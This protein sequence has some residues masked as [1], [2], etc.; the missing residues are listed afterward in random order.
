MRFFVGSILQCHEFMSAFYMI[1]FTEKKL[2][3]SFLP[4][5][6]FCLTL[7]LFIAGVVGKATLN[8]WALLFFVLE[9]VNIVVALISLSNDFQ[10]LAPVGE[11]A[12]RLVLTSFTLQLDSFMVSEEQACEG[13]PSQ[14]TEGPL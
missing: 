13:R 4:F 1:T 2:F 12:L 9:A 10:S 14:Q 6:F 3:L 11:K 7:L 8:L 5:V